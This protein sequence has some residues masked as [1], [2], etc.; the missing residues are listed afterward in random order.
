MGPALSRA[1]RAS[2]WA[3]WPSEETSGEGWRCSLWVAGR[4]GLARHGSAGRALPSS[5][6]PASPGLCVLIVPWPGLWRMWPLD[7]R[8]VEVFAFSSPHHLYSGEIEL[9]AFSRHDP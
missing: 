8:K 4:D 5:R 6:L 7:G 9:A 2:S 1:P 3:G